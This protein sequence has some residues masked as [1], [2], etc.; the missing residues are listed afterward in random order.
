MCAHAQALLDVLPTSVAPLCHEARRNS[1]HL[2]ISSFSLIFKDTEKRAPTGVV[3][4]LGQMMV[5]YHS[6]HVQIFHTNTAIPLRITFGRLELEVAALPGNLE[7]LAG[8]FTRGLVAAVTT[9]RAT[10]H[11]ALCM[12]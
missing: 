1:D 8:Y 6:K 2:M 3:N 5:S 9:F 11:A 12:C 10:A 7:V 4:V